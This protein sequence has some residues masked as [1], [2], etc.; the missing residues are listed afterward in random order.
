M[1]PIGWC[2]GAAPSPADEIA[3]RL[4][5]SVTWRGRPRRL[6]KTVHRHAV[7]Q[8]YWGECIRKY[9]LPVGITC[10]RGEP[11]G[12]DTWR[13]LLHVHDLQGRRWENAS[14]SFSDPHLVTDRRQRVQRR[15]GWGDQGSQRPAGWICAYAS[16]HWAAWICAW[17]TVATHSIPNPLA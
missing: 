15:S 5:R 10:Y 4:R 2:Y 17:W 3:R 8:W 12:R 14:N 6:T 13:I 16:R 9:S 7:T 1:L 11:G